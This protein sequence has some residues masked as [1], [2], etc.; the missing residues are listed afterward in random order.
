MESVKKKK[1]LRKQNSRTRSF[2]RWILPTTSRRVNTYL[3]QTI[4]KNCRGRNTSEH[5]IRPASPWYK[6]SDKDTIKKKKRKLQVNITNEIWGNQIQQYI[7]RVIQYDQM[8][9]I[10]GC[11]GFS[12]SANKSMWYTTLTNY[13]KKPYDNISKPRKIFWQNSTW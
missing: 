12:T 6:K 13:N 5:I 9:F 7:K 8:G 2:H 3:S 1:N 10:P 11:K 4:P